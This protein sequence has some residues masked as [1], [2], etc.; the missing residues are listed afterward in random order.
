MRP[1]CLLLL[2]IATCSGQSVVQP[3]TA[4]GG[5][6]KV[7]T[8]TASATPAFPCAAA[9]A[10]T[11]FYYTLAQAVTGSTMTGCVPGQK[12]SFTFTQNASVSY[13]LV[14][15][16]NILGPPAMV[17]DLGKYVAF[18]GEM[19]NTPNLVVKTSTTNGT[20]LCPTTA[21]TTVT[22]PA[23]YVAPRCD[24]TT[25]AITTQTSAGLTIWPQDSYVLDTGTTGS[26]FVGCPT[27]GSAT[28]ATGQTILFAA[29]HVSVGGASTI[30]FCGTSYSLFRPDGAT[31]LTYRE[32]LT[33]AMQRLVFNGTAWA[34]VTSPF[35][36]T[37]SVTLPAS[38][39]VPVSGNCLST[40]VSYATTTLTLPAMGLGNIFNVDFQYDDT[41]PASPATSETLLF[42][43][44][45]STVATIANATTGL[46][47]KHLGNTA[48]I[49]VTGLTAPASSGTTVNVVALGSSGSAQTAA[50][51]W[52]LNTTGTLALGFQFNCGASTASESRQAMVININQIN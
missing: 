22:V 2:S 33:T 3:S 41:L 10:P 6:G 31:N 48:R 45:G 34:E 44:G 19:N 24:S 39:V 38:D 42:Q 13:P 20:P 49:V 37:V 25:G 8:V 40:A 27:S 36:R 52:A 26:A 5:V 12:V 1:A 23:G 7:V 43:L 14:Y 28:P 17:P 18:S 9:G 50:T 15:P 21:Q 51:S 30:N 35:P 16:T 29:I 46:G 4:A 47:S 11:D 32:L